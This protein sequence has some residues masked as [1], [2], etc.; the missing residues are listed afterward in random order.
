M[1]TVQTLSKG[2]LTRRTILDAAIARFGRDGYR[3]TS[4]ADIARAAAVGGTVPYTYFTDKEALFFAALDEDAAA[5][6]NKGMANA[7][8]DL[9][10]A[11][12]RRNLLLTLVGAVE[13]HPLA[14][15]LLAGLEPEVTPR[16]LEIPALTELRKVCAARIEAQQVAGTV[17][18]DID[19]ASTANGIVAILL[20]LLMSIVQLGSE[21][22]GPYAADVVGIFEAALTGP[23]D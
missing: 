9:D 3:A 6:I 22:A 7:F 21:A 5:A 4:V 14:R 10:L 23:T 2:E 15:R 19:P 1:S 17:R 18:P 12:W 16:V 20:S 8:D 11:S 13:D